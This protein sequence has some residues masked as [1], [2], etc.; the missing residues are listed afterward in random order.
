MIERIRELDSDQISRLRQLGHDALAAI[1]P[2]IASMV[3]GNDPDQLQ[4]LQQLGPDALGA[5]SPQLADMLYVP[6]GGVTDQ[7]LGDDLGGVTDQ[8]LAKQR[9]QP[10][11]ILP[12]L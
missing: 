9:R 3:Y 11:I 1:S 5:M 6:A 10:P 4:A 2:P 12:P 8:G 7:G